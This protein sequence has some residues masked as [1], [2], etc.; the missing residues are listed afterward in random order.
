[1]NH[2]P[3]DKKQTHFQLHIEPTPR[4][5]ET[6]THKEPNHPHHPHTNKKSVR[7]ILKEASRQII[8]SLIIL[9]VGFFLLN[10]SAY[11]QIVLHAWEE[12]R[13]VDSAA[14]FNEMVGED[15][16]MYSQ[17]ILETVDSAEQQ[18]SSIPPLDIEIMPNDNRIIIPKIK[19]NLPVITVGS[20]TL[21]NRDFSKL[22]KEMQEA[23]RDGVVHYPGTSLPGMGGNT[24]ITGHSSY[25]PWDVGRFKDVFALL[26]NVD[27][28]DEIIVYQD[29]VKY[30]YKVT[31]K[32]EVK[33]EE[34]D[35]LKQTPNDKLT[36]IT[37]TP[38][39]TNTRR[40]IVEAEPIEINDIK[41]PKKVE[42]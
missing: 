22:E 3:E 2:T 24:V 9:V 19:Q 1:M 16:D 18:L 10:W 42:R 30:L 40:L 23:L 35:V 5:V 6:H 33:P 39:G 4:H 27:I 41:I 13:G 28:G 25:F 38:V 31:E 36:L 34:I 14:P 21:I 7:A 11:K 29:Q 12:Y 20:G 26:H 32:Y 17:K 37:C 15:K 8:A